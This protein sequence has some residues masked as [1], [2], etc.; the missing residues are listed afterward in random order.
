[1]LAKATHWNKTVISVS[2]VWL[3]IQGYLGYSGFYLDTAS[4]PPHFLAMFPPVFIAIFIL[5]YTKK[6]KIFIDSI[7]LKNL[8]LLHSVRIPVEICL[9]WLFYAGAIPELM[10]FE[11]RNFDIIAGI[12]APIVYYLYF[13]R[14]TI[15]K[16]TLRIW[17]VIMLLFLINIIINALLSTP[18]PIQQFAFD[19]PNI[20]ILYLPYVW[21]P[22][23]IVPAALFSHLVAIRRL[24][25]S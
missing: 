6:G 9:L 14:K 12:T 21:L 3:T 4:I 7:D 17:N 1:M 11:G 15:S 10:T 18:L 22:A 5:F 24:K 19:Q 23:F 16:K 20:G 2:I 8:T 25:N 13:K